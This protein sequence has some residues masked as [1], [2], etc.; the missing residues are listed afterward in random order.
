M[1]LCKVV[2]RTM[3]PAGPHRHDLAQKLPEAQDLIASFAIK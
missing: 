2:T 1:P 3:V